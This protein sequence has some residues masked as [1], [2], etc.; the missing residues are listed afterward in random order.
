MLVDALKMKHDTAVVTAMCEYMRAQQRSGVGEV[1]ALVGNR[2]T[3]SYKSGRAHR[4]R[5]DAS[6]LP[7]NTD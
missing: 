5:A 4:R 3:I 7:L 1:R 2:N 6:D